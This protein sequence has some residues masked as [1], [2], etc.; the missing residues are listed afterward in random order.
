MGLAINTS[1]IVSSTELVKNY[2]SIRNKVK[3]DNSIIVFKNNKPDIAL[4]EFELYEKLME[5]VELIE[6]DEIYKIV[7]E[8]ES[9]SCQYCSEEEMNDYLSKLIDGEDNK[10][11]V[12]Y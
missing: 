7:S 4:V 6:H 1:N 2:A 12:Q 3:K 9:S 8:R 5:L 11:V 10:E